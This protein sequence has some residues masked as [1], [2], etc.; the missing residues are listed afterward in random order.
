VGKYLFLAFTVIPLVELYLLLA[1]GRQFGFWPTLGSVVVTGLLGTVLARREGVRVLRAWQRSLSQGRVPEEGILG[2]VLV[3]VG[4][5]LLVAPGVL[6]D[7]TGLLLLFP[8]TRR[9]V[10]AG[11]RR[12]LER[13]VAS[14]RLRVTTFQAGPFARPAEAQPPTGRL[15]QAEEDAEFTEDAGPKR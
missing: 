6:T 5:V 1:M 9:L 7:V 2:G 13:R 8:P 10:A 12:M 14:G 3:L 4:G 15:R 11:V